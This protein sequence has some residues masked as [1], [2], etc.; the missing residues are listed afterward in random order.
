MVICLSLVCLVCSA[1]LGG[2]NLLTKDAID[3]AA[4][5]KT[6]KAIALVAP[7]F[8]NV[9]SSEE[10]TVSVGGEDMKVYPAKMAGQTVGYAVETFTSK[11]FGGTIKLMVGF[12]TEGNIVNTSVLSHS[13]TPGLGSKMTE[14]KFADQFRGKNPATFK[15]QVKKNGGDVDAITAS[16]ITSMAFCDAMEKAY[17]AFEQI[18][19]NS[20]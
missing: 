2:V 12:D 6:D 17:K 8:D 1:L 10:F 9:P 3:K 20:K 19:R 5:D 13:E 4:T 14:P 7:A 18:E 15:L 11:G 16:T